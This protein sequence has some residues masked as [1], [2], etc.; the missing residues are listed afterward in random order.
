MSQIT[1]QPPPNTP[2]P[3]N[4]PSSLP[5]LRP[6]VVA[7]P[8]KA[9]SKEAVKRERRTGCVIGVVTLLVVVIFASAGYLT[10]SFVTSRL[11]SYGTGATPTPAPTTTTS[12]NATLTYAGDEITIVDVKQSASFP[13]DADVLS[14]TGEIR[15]DIIDHNAVANTLGGFSYKDVAHIVLPTSKSISLI[16]AENILSPESTATRHNWLDFPVPTNIDV[17]ELLLRLGRTG[18]A[19]MD[20]LLKPNVDLSTYQSKTVKLH[21]TLHYRGLRWTIKSAELS[22][23]IGDQQAS[24]GMLYLAITLTA[25]NPTS[26]DFTDFPGGYMRIKVGGTTLAPTIGTTFPPT[27]QA[28]TMGSMGIVGFLVPQYATSFTFILL[29]DPTSQ[30]SQASANFEIQ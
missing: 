28:K 26:Q 13:D 1:P 9:E 18:E 23:S 24:A 27:I 11:S 19:Q 25:N 2:R 6:P 16:N 15:L 29:G 21:L 17:G 7:P 3:P 30:A 22:W 14:T 20:V 5:G 8:T 10:I 12:I 4:S